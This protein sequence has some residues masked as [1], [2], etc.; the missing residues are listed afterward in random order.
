[1]WVCVCHYICYL[2]FFMINTLIHIWICSINFLFTSKRVPKNTILPCILSH[3]STE[4]YSFCAILSFKGQKIVEKTTLRNV[5]AF[6]RNG[7]F[8]KVVL[9]NKIYKFTGNGIILV[10][11]HA[12]Y[13]KY[14]YLWILASLVLFSH[15]QSGGLKEISKSSGY[16]L[17]CL[18]VKLA[19]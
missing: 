14:A 1:M 3:P 19:I 9:V 16:T 13:H 5:C 6:P 18:L 8:S 2:S 17:V 11:F 15:S 4:I 12:V 10:E 7:T